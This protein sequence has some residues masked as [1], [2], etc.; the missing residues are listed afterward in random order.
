MKRKPALAATLAI[1]MI[2]AIIVPA[3]L[4]ATSSWTS[5]S[6][7]PTGTQWTN[8]DNAYADG[9]G[10]ASDDKQQPVVYYGYGFTIPAGS[11]IDGI[12][13]RLD[14]WGT[15]TDSERTL[16]L[17]VELSGDGGT[18]YTTT[19]KQVT[20]LGAEP[21]T[22]VI[23][24][25]TADT[26]GR[27]WT[28]AIINSDD[29]RVRLQGA[30]EGTGSPGDKVYNL[31]WVPVRITYT[32]PTVGDTIPPETTITSGPTG[33]INTASATFTWTGTDDTTST[34]NLVYSYRLD[35]GAWSTFSSGTKIALDSLSD[36]SHTF[37]V[38]AKDEAGNEDQSPASQSFSVDTV[39][40]T[41]TI[42]TPA[43]EAT[44]I[45]NQPVLAEWTATDS[46]SGIKTATGTAAS[47]QSIDTSTVGTKTFTVNAE[48][49][50]G[51]TATQTVTYKIVYNFAGF[52]TPINTPGHDANGFKK[53]ST[54]PV[55]FQVTDYYG[56][57]VTDAAATIS[58]KFI[59]GTAPLNPEPQAVSTSKAATSPNFRYDAAGN[60]Y[61]FNL[62]TKS[63]TAP[64][65]WQIT[66]NLNDGT[67]HSVLVALR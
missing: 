60:L 40:P 23:L 66:A 20:L 13:V 61:I 31:D 34:G 38:K 12:E 42:T 11:T 33:W 44:Y 10:I 59:S 54:I 45:L 65:V 1:L 57:H 55:K 53:G 7:N 16:T 5:P 29:F 30:T 47:G 27:S 21:A 52:L 15:I 50:A 51:N 14:A 67:S 64:A 18:S 9:T 48:D 37:E 46:G 63:L 58:L 24:G 56:A 6:K 39:A 28:A 4:A 49:N 17:K 3:A 41:I 19:G 2:T 32:A 36:G 22:E 8:P 43:D 26:W 35:G 25:G 62:N